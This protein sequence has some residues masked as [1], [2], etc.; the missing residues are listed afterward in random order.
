VVIVEDMVDSA[1]TLP[2]FH[3]LM[4]NLGGETRELDVSVGQRTLVARTSTAAT[5]LGA[6]L[7]YSINNFH[8]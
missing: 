3:C 7:C 1:V 2:S 6:Y 5:E 4:L 8:I